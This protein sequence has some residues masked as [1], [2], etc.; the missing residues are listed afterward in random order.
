[1]ACDERMLMTT[2]R[3]SCRVASMLQRPRT[4]PAQRL[5]TPLLLL[6]WK[7]VVTSVQRSGES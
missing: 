4:L 2:L 3:I 7:Y 5:L 1:M 6:I